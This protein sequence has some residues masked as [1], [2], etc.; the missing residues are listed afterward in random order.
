MS[1]KGQVN[2]RGNI[3][4][5]EELLSLNTNTSS[6]SAPFDYTGVVLLLV[7]HFSGTSHKHTQRKRSSGY[8]IN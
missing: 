1:L 5:E 2:F 7:F 3:I 4:S 8:E 6:G